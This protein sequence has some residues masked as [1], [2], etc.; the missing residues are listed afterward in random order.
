[1]EQVNDLDWQS[2]HSS[3]TVVHRREE[4][5]GFHLLHRWR[6]CVGWLL[7]V[8]PDVRPGFHLHG[9][10]DL[11]GSQFLQVG[12]M[13]SQIIT[14]DCLEVLKGLPDSSVHCCVTSPPYFGLRD[15]GMAGQIGMERT[16]T[17][18]TNT[19][20][21][22]FR[23]V[24]RIL[25]DDG[26]LWINLGDSYFGSGQGWGDTKTTNKNH[27]GSRERRKPEWTATGMKPKDLIGIPWTVA[28]ALRMDGWYLRSDIIWHKP[29]PM[30][31]SVT[32]RPTKSHEYIFLMSKSARYYYD[33]D[34]IREPLRDA[35]VAR[36][37]QDVEA[38]TGYDRVP[39]K[40]NGN[41]K[42]VRFGGNKHGDDESEF[43]RT[44]SGKEWNPKQA[45]S[46]GI[47]DNRSGYFD[48]DTGEPLC[49]S[50]ANKKS[51]WTVTTKGYSDAHF[52][53]FPPDLIEP[54]IKAG[55]A[56]G[57]TVLDPFSGAGTTGLVASRLGR[58]YIGIELNPA[59]VE[60]SQKRI[61]N[62]C[63]MFNEVILEASDVTARKHGG[64]QN[65]EAAHDSVKDHKRVMCAKVF[66]YI[67]AQRDR[68]TTSKETAAALKM[69][70]QTVSA[71]MADLLALEMIVE[72][73]ERRGGCGIRKAV[74]A[75]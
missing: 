49:G 39:G 28:F 24:R 65:S 2:F 64:N 53:T 44:K 12:K 10:F 40:T 33:Q 29:N 16:P 26:T 7:T 22:V 73:G 17:E 75:K 46:G 47:N 20:V 11:G 50:T 18:Y 54:C 8:S 48:K 21:E 23:E 58:N 63:P 31:E 25:K 14:G 6:S 55:C 59:Y 36:L 38:Q 60:M 3:W 72:S 34:A 61:E 66:E 69:P 71:R 32:D 9:V 1:L 42:A 57:G 56:E 67:V 13:K 45:G 37:I 70:L 51:V 52:A 30:P 74:F 62:D 43:S 27:N 15:Y 4:A 35:S 5:V 68:G 19:L 41:M